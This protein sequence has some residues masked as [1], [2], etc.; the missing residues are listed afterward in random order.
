MTWLGS[1]ERA[2]ASFVRRHGGG[3]S[4]S[5]KQLVATL[6]VLLKRGWLD[7]SQQQR[8]HF[9]QARASTE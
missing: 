1:W 8:H 6:A 3:G 7:M 2:R 4:L 5:G 9:F